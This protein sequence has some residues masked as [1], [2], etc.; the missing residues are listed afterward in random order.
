MNLNRILLLILIA[1][2]STID[3]VSQVDTLK[4]QLPSFA[5]GD[6]FIQKAANDSFLFFQIANVSPPME[7]GIPIL[8]GL[9]LLDLFDI[10]SQEIT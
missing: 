1:I 9:F 2:L 7:K 8:K 6:I 4:N 10:D 3:C 5:S